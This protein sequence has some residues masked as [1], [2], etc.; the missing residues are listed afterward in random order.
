MPEPAAGPEAR[1]I[2]ISCTFDDNG[3]ATAEGDGA[4]VSNY[5]PSVR[6]MSPFM[7]SNCAPQYAQLWVPLGGKLKVAL[8]P[9]APV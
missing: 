7:A 9:P 5:A 1:N 6:T 4:A 3:A 8:P 2:A